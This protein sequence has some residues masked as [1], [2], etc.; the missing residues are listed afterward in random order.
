[1][2]GRADAEALLSAILRPINESGGQ[3][4][5]DVFTFRTFVEKVY[6]PIYRQKWKM[7]TAE[8]EEYRLQVHL[9][10]NIGDQLLTKIDREKLQDVLNRAARNVGRD[11]LDHLRFRLR[12][13]FELAMSE[14]LVG[15]NPATA[16]FTPKQHKKGRKKLVLSKSQIP[17]MLGALELRERLIVRFALFEG[18][19]PSEILGL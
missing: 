8:T 3:K 19:R 15:R 11:L 17:I 1:M 12:S 14:G 16:L 6:L 10:R 5:Q 4:H 7:S 2:L 9:V 13:I 18:M